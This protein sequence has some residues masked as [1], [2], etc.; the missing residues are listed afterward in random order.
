MEAFKFQLSS[1]LELEIINGLVVPRGSKVFVGLE[2]VAL[3]S[4]E[5]CARA[6]KLLFGIR[7]RAKIIEEEESVSPAIKKEDESSE[8]E[9]ISDD[10][11][12]LEEAQED[13]DED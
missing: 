7:K 10:E 3:P 2:S 8:E 6:F 12:S 13:S 11:E 1:S 9:E 4:N 5:S